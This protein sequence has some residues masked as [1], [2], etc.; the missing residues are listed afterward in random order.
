MRY[1]GSL[2][3]LPRCSAHIATPARPQVADKGMTF[4]YRL[5][6]YFSWPR[7]IVGITLFIAGIFFKM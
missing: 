5:A 1:P 4:G 7:T 3:Y 2:G 6:S